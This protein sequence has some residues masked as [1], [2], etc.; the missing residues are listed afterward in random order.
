[1]QIDTGAG[2]RHPHV[3][4]IPSHIAAPSTSRRLPVGLSPRGRRC[5][6]ECWIY[7][8]PYYST[9]RY[10]RGRVHPPVSHCSRCCVLVCPRRQIRCW[11]PPCTPSSTPLLPPFSAPP[12]P[13]SVTR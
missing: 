9:R 4:P 11:P 2:R 1:M 10:P 8:Y 5:P 7:C 12:P 13:S 3:L 6:W